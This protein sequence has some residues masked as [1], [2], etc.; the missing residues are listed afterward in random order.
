MH[1][2]LS[3]C[4]DL[5]P[6]YKSALFN[7]LYYLVDGGSVWLDP[8]P[9]SEGSILL[10]SGDSPAVDQQLYLPLDEVRSRNPNVTLDPL[11][12]TPR[13]EVDKMKEVAACNGDNSRVDSSERELL[14]VRAAF[15]DEMGMFAYLEG[16]SDLPFTG[17]E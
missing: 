7:E 5:P 14:R 11:H 2:F 6:W 3:L 10:N 16:E 4:S 15:A 1:S 9:S 13:N 8:I 17:N 12:I